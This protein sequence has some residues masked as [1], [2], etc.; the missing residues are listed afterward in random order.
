MWRFLCS[1]KHST[2]LGRYQGMLL[3]DHMVVG[4]LVSQ[5]AFQSMM[6]CINECPSW[7]TSS[8]VLSITSIN[9]ILGFRHPN[10]SVVMTHCCFKVEISNVFAAWGVEY[11]LLCLLTMYMH[12]LVR[13]LFIFCWFKNICPKIWK[14]KIFVHFP[15]AEF[16]KNFCV[17]WIT[18]LYKLFF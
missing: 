14:I 9:S 4:C 5:T 12:L 13:D 16:K 6:F 11:L 15:I 7:L 10:R 18:V 3:L 1:L 17:S 8:S 2:H